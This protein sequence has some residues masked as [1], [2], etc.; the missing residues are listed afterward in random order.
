MRHHPAGMGRVAMLEQVNALPRSKRHA[1]VQ[2]GNRH[3]DWKQ[4]RLDMGGHI[5]GS[6]VS[7]GQV[8]HGWISGWRHQP[9]KEGGQIGPDLGVRVFLDQ[10]AGRRVLYEQCKNATARNPASN[11]IGEFVQARPGCV[12]LK[13]GLH[14]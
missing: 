12:Y 14:K 10:K 11:I 2:N 7:V 1:P 4:R 13:N 5:V 9:L 8:G 6:F 3:A